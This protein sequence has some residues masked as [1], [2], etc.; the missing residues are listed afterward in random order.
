MKNI[1]GKFWQKI[2][3]IYAGFI[4]TV[5]TAKVKFLNITDYHVHLVIRKLFIKSDKKNKN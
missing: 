5:I 3:S 4:K 2:V 1:D